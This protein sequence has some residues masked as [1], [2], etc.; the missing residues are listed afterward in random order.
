MVQRNKKSHKLVILIFYISI[1]LF[2]FNLN[3]NTVLF[4]NRAPTDHPSQLQRRV[5]GMLPS[6]LPHMQKRVGRFSNCFSKCS[7]RPQTSF[8]QLY[9]S[10]F[11]LA[12]Q[13]FRLLKICQT[14]LHLV[15]SF[16]CKIAEKSKDKVKYLEIGWALELL[17]K[18]LGSA[19]HAFQ[20][21]GSP[22]LAKKARFSSACF[23]HSKNCFTLE[24]KK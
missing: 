9:L 14:Q 16:A 12:F 10:L 3:P 24:S 15:G 13:T 8:L 19:R 4:T 18:K 7:R 20:K 5:L 22:Y 6:C 17:G 1:Q 21:L 11:T 2:S 23:Y